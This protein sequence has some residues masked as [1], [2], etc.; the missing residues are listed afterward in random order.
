LRQCPCNRNNL[1]A[2]RATDVLLSV[3]A[4]A[5]W[6]FAFQPK[7]AVYPNLIEPWWKVLQGL[8]LK[9]PRFESWE[10]LCRAVEEATAYWNKRRHPF[11]W[12]RRR[13]HRTRRRP[14]IASVPDVRGL[15]G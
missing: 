6:E 8:A 4:F 14:R 1:Q 2:H 9:E 5:R 7:Y 3:P 11:L 12:G 15:A 13:R 10:D